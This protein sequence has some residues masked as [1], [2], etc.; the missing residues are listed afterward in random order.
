LI[1][2]LALKDQLDHH[3]IFEI[4]KASKHPSRED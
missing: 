2:E 4:Q 3:G 1:L